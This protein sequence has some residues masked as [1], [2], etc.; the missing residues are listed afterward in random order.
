MCPRMTLAIS[1]TMASF[2]SDG[3]A[4]RIKEALT[5]E[6]VAKRYGYDPNRT[7]FV[8]CP[9]HTG[10]RT[11]SLKLYPSSGGW[12]CFGC[13]KGGSVI[14]FV[15]ELFG[16]SFQQALL[17]INEDFGLGLTGRRPT[18][19]EASRAARER[20][21]EAA[22]LNRYRREYESRT[23]LYR[24]LWEAK[25]TGPGAPLYDTACR[26]LDAMDEWFSQNPWR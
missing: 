3:L 22:R 13:G 23:V 6:Q 15:M 17:R 20:S 24:A 8:S 25:Q 7:G 11:A 12:H 26:E 21:E 10:D 19:A 9:F 14:D 16:I 1:R 18:H 2:R 5:A 4:G